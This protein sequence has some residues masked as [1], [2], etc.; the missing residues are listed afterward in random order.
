MVNFCAVVGCGKRS[1][2]DEGITLSHLDV[3]AATTSIIHDFKL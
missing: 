1:D 3:V 2:R